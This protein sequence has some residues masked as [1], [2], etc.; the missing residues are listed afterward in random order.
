MS[1]ITIRSLFAG[2]FPLVLVL[3]LASAPATAQ[4]RRAAAAND[5]E[6]EPRFAEF[7]GVRIGMNADEA[8]K[9][10]GTPRDKSDELDLYVF[11]EKEAVQIIYDKSRVVSAISIDFMGGADAPPAKDVVG[12]DIQAKAD[13]SVYRLVRYPKAGFWVSYSRTAG[14]SPLISITLQRIEK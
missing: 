11:N 7:K 4:Q 8:R 5:E 10:L 3:V 12:S 14:D 2:L 1:R 13:G 6:Q 9:K